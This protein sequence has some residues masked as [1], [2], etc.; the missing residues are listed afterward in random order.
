MLRLAFLTFCALTCTQLFTASA[1]ETSQ[2]NMGVQI[3]NSGP[4]DDSY[5]A[6]EAYRTRT[7]IQCQSDALA[8]LKAG[9]RLKLW[10]QWAPTR[11]GPWKI[12]SKGEIELRANR[13]TAKSHEHPR[14]KT[15]GYLTKDLTTEDTVTLEMMPI[16][17]INWD[18]ENPP[19][20]RVAQALRQPGEKWVKQSR[21]RATPEDNNAHFTPPFQ[22]EMD[23]VYAYLAGRTAKDN[24]PIPLTNTVIQTGQPGP[25]STPSFAHGPLPYVSFFVVLGGVNI[26]SVISSHPFSVTSSAGKLDFWSCRNR[27][28]GFRGPSFDDSSMDSIWWGVCPLYVPQPPLGE[29]VTVVITSTLHDKEYSKSFTVH[30]LP[31]TPLRLADRKINEVRLKHLLERIATPTKPPVRSDQE[32]A[33]EYLSAQGVYNEALEVYRQAGEEDAA[34]LGEAFLTL[35][36]LQQEDF[37]L[38][39]AARASA[40]SKTAFQIEIA[41]TTLQNILSAAGICENLQD[42]DGM[43]MHLDAY[44]QKLN[45]FIAEGS[46]RKEEFFH[47]IYQSVPTRNQEPFDHVV[48]HANYLQ[49]LK[50]WAWTLSEPDSYQQALELKRELLKGAPDSAHSLDDYVTPREYRELAQLIIQRTGR[51]NKAEGCWRKADALFLDPDSPFFDTKAD[52]SRLNMHRPGWWLQ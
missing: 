27:P 26:G 10:V 2:V 5:P 8:T 15:R 48:D 25:W 50:S 34:A 17:P 9:E 39:T 29:S 3:V 43:K 51:R 44:M 37:Y 33:H 16:S 41:A 23:I 32:L 21:R 52:E 14:F 12:H 4:W 22:T 1:S 7:W 38:R 36:T 42:W 46:I 13:A 49:L 45:A 11:E 6:R 47:Y 35:L 19:Y 18:H 40:L 24:I 31:V 30:G 20:F 28:K